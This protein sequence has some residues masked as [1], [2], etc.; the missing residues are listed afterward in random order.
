M[1]S[2]PNRHLAYHGKIVEMFIAPYVLSTVYAS[3][4]QCVIHTTEAAHR[5]TLLRKASQFC[6]DAR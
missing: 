3:P 1:S 6:T 2:N 5:Q 4:S